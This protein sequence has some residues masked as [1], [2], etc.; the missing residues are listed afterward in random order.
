MAFVIDVFARR[1]VGYR[2]VHKREEVQTQHPNVNWQIAMMAGQRRA[3]MDKSQPINALKE[4]LE[5]VKASIRVKVE[6]QFRVLKCQFRYRK[7]HY[8]GLAKKARNHRKTRRWF[9]HV[10]IH[11]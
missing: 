5:K 1:I 9:H 11:A 8:R 6:H 10:D 2:G 4:L 3:I 7:V